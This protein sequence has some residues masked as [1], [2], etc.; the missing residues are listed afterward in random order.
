[1]YIFE[2][3]VIR[4]VDGD[5]VDAEIDLGFNV[6]IRE[7][8]RIG[9]IDTPESR[10]RNKREKSWGLASKH[11][12]IELLD[13]A[14]NKFTIHMDTNNRGKYGRVLGD[15]FVGDANVADILIEEKLAIPYGGRNKKKARILHGVSKLWDTYYDS[16]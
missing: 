9:S 3:K 4:V 6:F 13:N 7:R 14:N 8:I 5:T 10:T 11:R 15:I 1:M 2:C 16:E 12:L